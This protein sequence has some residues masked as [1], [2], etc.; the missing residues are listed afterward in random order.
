MVDE[1]LW[2]RVLIFITVSKSDYKLSLVQ[3]SRLILGSGFNRCG[4]SLFAPLVS[5]GR[6]EELLFLIK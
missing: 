5:C 1:C 4:G 3:E 2:G 6:E